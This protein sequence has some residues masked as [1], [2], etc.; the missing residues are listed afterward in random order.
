MSRMIELDESQIAIIKE[1]LKYSI[2]QLES[3]GDTPYELRRDKIN[4][5]QDILVKLRQT[6]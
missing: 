4:D 6:H 2:L 1:S 3:S 5:I